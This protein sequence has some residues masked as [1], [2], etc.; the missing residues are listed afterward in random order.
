MTLS[1]PS[2]RMGRVPMT[3]YS[4]SCVG[5]LVSA[6]AGVTCATCATAM[7]MS[8]CRCVSVTIRTLHLPA[9]HGSQAVRL[10]D[11]AALGGYDVSFYFFMSSIIDHKTVGW[12]GLDHLVVNRTVRTA[13]ACRTSASFRPTVLG[14]RRFCWLSKHFMQVRSS[15]RYLFYPTESRHPVTADCQVATTLDGKRMSGVRSIC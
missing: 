3:V 12:P 11:G 1:V 6:T 14:R 2:G 7:R 8:P 4:C 13:R 9:S 5:C 10:G 15:A